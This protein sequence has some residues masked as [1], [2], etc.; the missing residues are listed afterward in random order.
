MGLRGLTDAGVYFYLLTAGVVDVYEANLTGNGV[1]APAV[2]PTSY[3]GSNISSLWSPDGLRLAY[4][5]RRG[6][7]WFDRASTTLAITNL[8]THDQQELAPPM[9]GFLLRSWSPDGRRLLVNGSGV[10]HRQGTY[11]IDVETG[12]VIAVQVDGSTARPDWLPD[13]RISYFSRTRRA[14][15]ARDLQTAVEEVLFDPRNGGGQIVANIYGR[16]YRVSPDGHMLAYTTATGEGRN[17]VESLQIRP[18]NGGPAREVARS[19]PP[20]L[21]IFQDWT[22]DGSALLFTRWNPDTN[23]PVALWRASIFGGDPQPLGLSMIGLRDVTVHPDGTKITFTA[24][25][26]KNENLE[27]R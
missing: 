26:P 27:H 22:P 18:L 17:E 1:E 6:V 5:S 16:G 11:Q 8:L 3:A 15:M 20:S 10:D 19:A 21:L 9:N 7:T 24:G 25:W 13:G 2:L 12:R 4:A 14:I 23:G